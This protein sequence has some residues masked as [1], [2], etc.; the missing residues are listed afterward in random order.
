MTELEIW[1]RYFL[2][3]PG[4]RQ[5]GNPAKADVIIIRA[6]GRNSIPDSE[7]HLV[8]QL[9]ELCGNDWITINKLQQNPICFDPGKPNFSLALEC[10]DL[11]DK[12]HLPIITQWEV[13]VAFGPKWYEKHKKNIYCIWPSTKPQKRFSTRDVMFLTAEIMAKHGWNKPII[14]AHKRHIARVYLIAKKLLAKFPV[15]VTQ[16]TRCFDSRSI[17]KWTRNWLLWFVYE[18]LGRGYHL[19]RQWV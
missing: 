14:L 4:L 16:K 7:L 6:F 19:L 15:V 2:I 18:M 3:W 5:M 9:Q 1:I 12:Y 17:Q 11:V 13:A 8:A 10:Q